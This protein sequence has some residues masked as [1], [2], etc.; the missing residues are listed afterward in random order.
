MQNLSIPLIAPSLGGIKTL[1]TRPAITSHSEMTASERETIGITDK[2]LRLS[3]GIEAVE[4]LI[5]D[6][7]QALDKLS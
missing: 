2:L 6:F 4:D 5:Q 3:V 7:E 1:I